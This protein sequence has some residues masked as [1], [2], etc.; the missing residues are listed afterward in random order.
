MRNTII[1]YNAYDLH[2][3]VNRITVFDVCKYDFKPRPTSKHPLYDFHK[4]SEIY[5]T[6]AGLVI[7]LKNRLDPSKI[8]EVK[9]L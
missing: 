5:Y 8:G 7:C 6:Y 1:H 2:P 4:A 3:S 9:E